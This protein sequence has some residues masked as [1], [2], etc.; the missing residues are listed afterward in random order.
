MMHII[1]EIH[2]NKL[3]LIPLF[4]QNVSPISFTAPLSLGPKNTL[5]MCDN[6]ILILGP[7]NKS[8]FYKKI[9]LEHLIFLV[10]LQLI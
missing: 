4:M 3:E 8:F 6:V 1:L 7:K 10:M 9:I 5:I 2:I